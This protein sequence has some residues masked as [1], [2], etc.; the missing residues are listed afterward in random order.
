MTIDQYAR[1]A[2]RAA[3]DAAEDLPLVPL[4]TVDRVRRR[5]SWTAAA[6]GL[7]T[8]VVAIVLA[9]TVRGPE[10][11]PVA[12]DPTT[13]VV[14]ST[15]LPETGAT[16]LPDATGTT[17]PAQQTSTTIQ[18]ETPLPDG[19]GLEAPIPA[20]GVDADVVL[21]DYFTIAPVS[22]GVIGDPIATAPFGGV[23]EGQ[24]TIAADG[25]GGFVTLYDQSSLLWWQ[26]DSDRPTHVE[27]Q[28]ESVDATLGGIVEVTS[29]DGSLSAIVHYVPGPTADV[30]CEALPL[31]AAV[32]LDTGVGLPGAD[33]SWQFHRAGGALEDQPPSLRGSSPSPW[34]PRTGR[35]CPPIRRVVARWRRCR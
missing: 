22:G 35:P 23:L 18:A 2:A 1:A 24:Q 7:G 31:L 21:Y 29:L 20:G 14:P 16:T 26:A 10:E 34:T 15:T 19:V 9:T 13:T 25:Q 17:I 8:V 6:V 28:L 5:R 30:S 3:L 32:S 11:S 12:T 33:S 4:H 27:V